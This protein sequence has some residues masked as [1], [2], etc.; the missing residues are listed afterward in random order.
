M[1]AA[2]PELARARRCSTRPSAC[3]LALPVDRRARLP[4]R[5]SS[6]ATARPS[7]GR[8]DA[9]AASPQVARAT[10]FMPVEFS[11]AAYRFGHSMVRDDYDLNDDVNGRCRSSS[12]GRR[13][14]SHLGGFRRLPPAWR[15]S[16]RLLR[17][18]RRAAPQQQPQI[19]TKLRAGCS[20]FPAR[21]DR[22]RRS[23]RLNLRR[24]VALGLPAAR[25]SRA[26]WSVKPLSRD[27]AEL[28]DLPG[29]SAPEAAG[30]AR[31]SGTTSCARR[32][33]QARRRAP[34][35][36]RR[37]DRRRG[38]GRAARGRSAVLPA[39]AAGLDGPRCPEHGRATFTMAD[40]VRF[41]LARRLH[42]A[43]EDRGRRA[44][45]WRSALPGRAQPRAR[46]DPARA[47]S[48]APLPRRRRAVPRARAGRR[49]ARA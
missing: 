32:R 28:G 45:A 47:R 14:R 30:R 19:D 9:A 21:R 24:G 36:G 31:R 20:S 17:A 16:G 15:S 33:S 13:S 8:H 10:P 11:A 42:A 23:L 25:T 5:G 43:R 1:L 40:L 39:R 2:S 41:T 46:R 6:G 3:A 7:R 38:P 34:R 37:P 35:A 29:A 22:G 49:R 27:D 44:R 18:R 48:H 4:A 26:R 12:R